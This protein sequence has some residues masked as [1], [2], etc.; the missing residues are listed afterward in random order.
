MRHNKKLQLTNPSLIYRTTYCLSIC[1]SV[2]LFIYLFVYLPVFKDIDFL[3]WW[4]RCRLIIIGRGGIVTDAHVSTK[5]LAQITALH[6]VNL[7]PTHPVHRPVLFMRGKPSAT[8]HTRANKSSAVYL[9]LSAWWFPREAFFFCVTASVKSEQTA[10]K[11][12]RVFGTCRPLS[13]DGGKCLMETVLLS[14]AS[15]CD[16]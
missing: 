6:P 13:S 12:I 16:E 9:G 15:M 4:N 5:G 2:C 11:P 7:Y 8:V 10:S 14:N 1:S 3:S